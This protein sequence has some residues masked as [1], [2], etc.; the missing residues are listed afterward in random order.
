MSFDEL[1]ASFVPGSVIFMTTIL[2]RENL[3]LKNAAKLKI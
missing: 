3:D 2:Y 1:T